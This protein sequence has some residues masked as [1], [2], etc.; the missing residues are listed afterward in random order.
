M[1]DSIPILTSERVNFQT[2]ININNFTIHFNVFEE[3]NHKQNSENGRHSRTIIHFYV[4]TYFLFFIKEWNVIDL[5]NRKK[6][7]RIERNGIKLS[8]LV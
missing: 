5:M 6:W 7:N 2:Q 4:H 8:N 3:S 1:G